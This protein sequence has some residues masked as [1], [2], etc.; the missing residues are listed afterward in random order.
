MLK[1]SQLTVFALMTAPLVRMVQDPEYLVSVIPAG[2]PVQFLSGNRGY[3]GQ[4]CGPAG[5]GLA[6]G[7]GLAEGLVVVG[8]ELPGGA[9]ADAVTDPF[10]ELANG[11]PGAP[12]DVSRTTAAADA[13]AARTQPM[14]SAT[15]AHRT[16]RDRP[17]MGSALA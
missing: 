4:C 16:G 10:P 15:R 12:P 1:K 7:D 11:S 6:L 2:T 14:A 8:L 17:L 3:A 5:L 9:E 13:A